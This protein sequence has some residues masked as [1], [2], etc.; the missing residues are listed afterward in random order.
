MYRSSPPACRKTATSQMPNLPATTRCAFFYGEQFEPFAAEAINQ[1]LNPHGYVYSAGY[2]LYQKPCFFLARLDRT[3]ARNG[4]TLFIAGKEVARDL[5]APPAMLQGKKIFIRQES[6]RRFIWEKIEE[7][8]QRTQ[9]ENP[10][11]RAL[12]CYENLDIETTLDRMTENEVE[13]LILHETG[14]DRVHE[15]LGD[16]WERLLFSLPR[17]R[18]EFLLR[19][20]RDNLADSI[21]T[22][23]ALIETNNVAAL[24]FYF[25]NF[26]GMRKEIFP[27]ALDA[28]HH[29]LESGS[30]AALR[31]TC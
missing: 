7:L 6:L 21:A 24:H 19:A 25:A 8:G 12:A 15:L 30:L 16:D 29:W 18:S 13:T 28:Y 26:T 4:T 22:L 2:G 14:E 1:R 27:L 23:P 17:S 9:A 31:S 11:A 3:E 20:V 10:M 5:A